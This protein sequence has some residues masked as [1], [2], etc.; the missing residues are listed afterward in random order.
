MK[1]VITHATRYIY[2][3]PVTESVNEIRLTPLTNNRQSCFHHELVTEPLSSLFAYEDYFGNRV[4]VFSINKY[5]KELVILTRA[6]VATEEDDLSKFTHI[7]PK[8]EIH[9][10]KS[11]MIYNRYIEYLLPTDYTAESEELREYAAQFKINR[12][13]LYALVRQISKS[14]FD[15]FTYDPYASNVHT[16]V[17]ETLQLRRGVCQDYAH[18]MIAICRGVGIPARYVSGY[19]FVGDLTGGNAD[20]EQASHAWV[21]VY[22]PG[23]GW[24]GLDPTNNTEIGG[25]YVKIGH[26]RDYK[27]IVPVKGIYHGTF[28]HKMEV[29]VDVQRLEG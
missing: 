19:H 13:G 21:E 15:D 24:R 25:R 4:H 7:S 3:E 26:G 9:L 17:Q 10:L 2:E 16:T 11:D 27:D 20:F 1:I 14:L 6:I 22:I 12:D 23:S 18:L 29:T 28:I 5:H 8:E